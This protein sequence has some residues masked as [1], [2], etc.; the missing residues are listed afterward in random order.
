MLFKVLEVWP[1]RVYTSEAAL[2][3]EI[4]RALEFDIKQSWFQGFGS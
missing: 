4:G 2:V 3:A 1:R